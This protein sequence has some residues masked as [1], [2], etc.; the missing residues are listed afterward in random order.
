MNKVEFRQYEKMILTPAP[1]LVVRLAVPTTL[2]M[3]IT[4]VYNLAD[5]YFVGKLSTSASAAVGVV[6][7][8]QAVFQSFGFMFG[9]GAGSNISRRLSSSDKKAANRFFTVSFISSLAVGTIIMLFGLL[10]ITPFMRFIGS[11]ETILPYSRQYA[12][13]ILASGPALCGSCVL[14]NVLRF[15]GKA[16]YAMIGLVSGGILNM[17]GDPVFMFMFNMGIDGAGL[18]TAISQY[19]SFFILL[20]MVISGNT[21]SRFKISYALE[22]FSEKNIKFL[23]NI[24]QTGFPSLI[25]QALNSIGTSVLNRCAMPYGDAAIAAMTIA[26]RVMMFMGSVM[27]GI[28]QGFQPVVAYSYGAKKYERVRKSYFATVALSLIVMC[29][30][31]VPSF[32]FSEKIVAL[33]RKDLLVMQYG[34]TALKCMCIAVIMQPISVSANMLFQS[35]G[36]S[37]T[38]SFLALLRSG[39]YYIPL[40]LILPSFFNIFGLQSAQMWADFL[41]TITSLPFLIGF[42][43]KLPKKDERT[44]IDEEYELEKSKI[45]I[46][47]KKA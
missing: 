4:M 30:I 20:Y 1:R 46:P 33:F 5:S 37:K 25:R 31:A 2:S 29:I 10:F 15:E 22:G 18:S 47:L 6:M 40:V 24:I 21:I 35:I 7:V 42:F 13:Y 12:Y 39:L 34:M 3:M 45:C 16:F 38:A 32:V 27:I 14:N 9:Q 8:I 11:T 43:M 41:T 19:I 36:M 28:G 44:L 17:L 26:G 23:L